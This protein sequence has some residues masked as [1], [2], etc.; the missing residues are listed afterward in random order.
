MSQISVIKTNMVELEFI[1]KALDDLG[2]EYETENVH[3]LRR[4]MKRKVNVLIKRDFGSNIGLIKRGKTYGLI[5]DWWSVMKLGE[6]SFLNQLQQRYA[7]HAAKAKLA[8]QGF[9]LIEEKTTEDGKI[10]I[11]LRRAV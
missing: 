4:G 10:Q 11:L 8:E 2:M 5:A 9:D 6:K 3:I 1:L 7:Y